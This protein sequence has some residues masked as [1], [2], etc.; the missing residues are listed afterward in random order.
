M[1]RHHQVRPEHFL[2]E[3]HRLDDLI[4]MIRAERGL[5]QLLRRL[6]GRKILLTNA[7]RHSALEVVRHL[8]VGHHFSRHISIESMR[9]HGQLR[10]KPSRAMLLQLLAREKLAPHRCVLVEDTVSHLKAAKTLGL[11]TAWVTQ[12]MASNPNLRMRRSALARRPVYVDVKVQS[13]RQLPNRL[14]RLR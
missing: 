10:R 2:D 1:V 8:G 6:P 5:G 12:Y 13:V 3:A 4:S 14:Q 11:R 9:V 7:P